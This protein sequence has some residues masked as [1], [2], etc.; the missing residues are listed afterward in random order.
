MIDFLLNIALNNVCISLA[1]A[2]VAV[3]VGNTLK[4]P[5]IT[6]LLWLLVFIKLLMPP[7]IMIPAISIPLINKTAPAFNVNVN[8]SQEMRS[9]EASYMGDTTSSS[10]ETKSVLLTH[11][12]QLMFLLW[13][14]GSVVIFLWSIFQACRFDR[15][16]KMESE[17]APPEIQSIA[18]NA[19]SC[20]GL[21]AV[22][23][24]RT[25]PANISP[26][27]WWA[28]GKLCLVIPSTLFE[29][30]DAG[31]LRLILAHELAHISRWDYLCRWIEWM[32]CVCFWWNPVVWWSKH[33]LR[34]NEEICCDEL[35]LSSMKPE[36]YTYGDTLLKAID[37]LL[38]TP[39]FQMVMASNFNGGDLLKIRMKLI[40]S[41][42]QSGSKLRWLNAC[43]LVAAVFLLP[44]GIMQAKDNDNNELEHHLNA[45][46]KELDKASEEFSEELSKKDEFKKAYEQFSKNMRSNPAYQKSMRDSITQSMLKGYDPLFKKLNISKEEFDEFKS[47]LADRMQEVQNSTLP[48]ILTASAEAKAE[49]NQRMME[50]KNKYKDKVNEFLGEENL[51]IYVD[52]QMRLPVRSGLNNF[53]DTVP[54]DNRISE[55]QTETLIDSMYAARKAVYDEMGPDI[56]MNLSSNLTEENVNRY[57]DK[58][59]M[60]YDKY[61]E[62][63]RGVLPDDQAE[64]YKAYLN[65]NLEMTESMMKTQMFMLK[66]K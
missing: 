65:R 7:L 28:G 38:S 62:A 66:N 2:I 32:A 13:P 9:F 11:G 58:V 34:V 45:V 40:I 23:I 31:Q 52:Y 48:N 30:M 39:R 12:K 16:L 63:I 14:A 3:I 43:I 17:T 20:L 37:I 53:M 25:T 46:E 61:M 18:R 1:L 27:V 59:K 21:K 36:P 42:S 54:P 35:V 50:I 64:Q 19:A 41:K 5:V 24:I 60:V 56:D 49:M 44:L 47:I 29:R 4:R 57:I 33:N 22:P 10:Q 55:E 6:H 26:M 51:K 8:E 15:L